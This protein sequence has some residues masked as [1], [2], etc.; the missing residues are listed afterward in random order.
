MTG[1]QDFFE[2]LKFLRRSDSLSDFTLR[3]ASGTVFFLFSSEFVCL[4]QI[5]KKGI[6]RRLAVRDCPEFF[7][8]FI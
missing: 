4:I 6:Y 7:I 1:Q 3:E 8:R 2:F 5:L